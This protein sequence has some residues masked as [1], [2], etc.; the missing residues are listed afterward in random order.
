MTAAQFQQTIA[1]F[2]SFVINWIIISVV[3]WVRIFINLI[4]FMISTMIR[5]PVL[6]H[7]F[8]V[9]SITVGFL[10]VFGWFSYSLQLSEKETYSITTNLWYLFFIPG[11]TGLLLILHPFQK[12]YLI[13]MTAASI[14]A[15]L[16]V[17]GYFFPVG[18]H[19]NLTVSAG[20]TA[21]FYAYFIAIIANIALSGVLKQATN[22][23]IFAITEQAKASTQS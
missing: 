17:I 15:L 7:L 5:L 12:A 18:I 6:V 1:T 8:V 19:Y 23:I 11:V 2:M 9:A 21:F 22:G 16:F 4:R 20:T 10:P 3:G 14:A 13:Q